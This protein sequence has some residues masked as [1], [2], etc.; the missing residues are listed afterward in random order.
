[1]HCHVVL[2]S[3]HGDR[4]LYRFTTLLVS[5]I[6]V[7]C[8]MYR[9][10]NV[11]LIKKLCGYGV[12][13]FEMYFVNQTYRIGHSIFHI[14]LYGVYDNYFNMARLIDEEEKQSKADLYKLCIK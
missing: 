7:C 9:Q 2:W 6:P 8:I 14:L 3:L 11:G 13:A 5:G 10:R 4:P 12:L 1:M